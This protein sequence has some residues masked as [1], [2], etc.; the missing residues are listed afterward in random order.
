MQSERTEHLQQE[1]GSDLVTTPQMCSVES[2]AEAVVP[3]RGEESGKIA[4]LAS[5][6]PRATVQTR[7]RFAEDGG[8]GASLARSLA[9]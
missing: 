3:S 8:R 1:K 6:T 4:P 7:P 5:R 2:V 9:P